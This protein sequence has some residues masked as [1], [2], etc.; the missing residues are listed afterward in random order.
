M[1]VG[2]LVR[3]INRIGD[4]GRGVVRRAKRTPGCSPRAAVAAA[5]VHDEVLVGQV[6]D[7]KLR[8]AQAVTGGQRGD[9]HRLDAAELDASWTGCSTIATLCGLR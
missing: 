9:R 8:G 1:S 5:L 2:T 4:T 3:Q 6:G 7:G